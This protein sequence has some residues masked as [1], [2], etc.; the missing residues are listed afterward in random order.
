MIDN[1]KFL[2][3]FLSPKD[4]ARATHE[5]ASHSREALPLLRGILDGTEKNDWEVP[6]R[7]LGMP[8]DCALVTVRL[9]G[10]TAKPLEELVRRELSAGQPYAADALAAILCSQ[11]GDEKET[12]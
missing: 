11:P 6:Y 10:A 9:L 8:V 2:R 1:E 3:A 12:D 7:Q 5:L 4:R